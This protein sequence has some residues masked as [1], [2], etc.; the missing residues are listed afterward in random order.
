VQLAPGMSLGLAIGVDDQVKDESNL[1]WGLWQY[2]GLPGGDLLL[3]PQL[4]DPIGDLG[5]LQGRVAWADTAEGQYLGR[6]AIHSVLSADRLASPVR[7]QTDASGGYAVDLPAGQYQI[8]AGYRRAWSKPLAVEIRAGQ[9]TLGSELAFARPPMGQPTSAGK[10]KT[11]PT[12]PGSAKGVWHTYD[13]LDGLPTIIPRIYQD[14]QGNLWM[15]TDTDGVFRYNGEETL[16]LTRDDGLI[17]NSIWSIVEDRQG[18]MWFGARKINFS[19]NGVSRYDGKQFVNFTI[20]TAADGLV[21]DQ[22]L[23]IFEDRHGSL[24]FGSGWKESLGQ[25]KGLSRYDGQH[26]T[27]FT[28]ADGLPSNT[29]TDIA[30]DQ[31][32]YLWLATNQGLSRYDGQRFVN[33]SGDEGLVNSYMHCVFKDRDGL[34]WTGSHGGGL[35]RYTGNRLRHFTQADGL[36]SN[37]VRSILKTRLGQLLFGSGNGLSRYT[38]EGFEPFTPTK[39]SA[40][41]NIHGL[42]EDSR[43]HLW[44]GTAGSGVLRYDGEQFRQFTTTDGLGANIALAVGEGPEGHIWI[45]SDWAGQG[46]SRYDGKEIIRFTVDDGL[47]GNSVAA[48]GLGPYGKFLWIGTYTGLSRYDGTQFTNFG[49]QN[50]LASKVVGAIFADRSDHLWFGGRGHVTRYDGQGFEAI[51]LEGGLLE[52]NVCSITQDACGRLYFG[53]SGGGVFVYDGLAFQHL[54]TANGLPSNSVK[55]VLADDEGTIWIGTEAGLTRYR[56]QQTTPAIRLI[57]LIADRHYGVVE[58]L[59]LPVTQDFFTVEYRGRSFGT[60]ADQ[61]VYAYRLLG[62]DEAWQTTHEEKVLYRDLP[63]GNYTFEVKAI[64]RDLNYSTEIA[65]VRIRLHPPYGQIGWGLGLGL[66]VLAI[67]V[68]GVRLTRQTRRLQ[69]TNA[70]LTVAR[71]EAES[72]NRAKSLFLANISHEIRTPMNAILGFAQLLQRR[73]DLNAEHRH[74]IN[75]I[76]HSGD[77]LLGLINEVL[78]I[79]KIEVGQLEFL[80][81]KT[82]V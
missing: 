28:T 30:E 3:S 53:T 62:H 75:T 74:A 54:S 70:S 34:L 46:A 60:Q 45:S 37:A 72:A 76:R 65:Q 61:M 8:T 29:I 55:E 66:A 58:S 23:C 50:G 64:D 73:T 42:Y 14:R 22:V 4:N 40:G 78:D 49:I 32:G 11:R 12:G 82:D 9:T 24:W 59:D 47:A 5:R 80:G 79:S 17:S 13:A 2:Q 6:L 26:F 57:N 41:Y 67:V 81:G 20:F 19:G 18:N 16:H 27:R 63:R 1:T 7:I 71:D 21:T 25:G 33:F 77:H 43:G 36:A 68:L 56:P 31:D 15:S 35:S 69:T 39:A 48:F 38:G 52:S 44:L 51:A 10:G